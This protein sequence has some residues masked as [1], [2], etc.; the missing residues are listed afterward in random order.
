MFE[1]RR[2]WAFMLAV[3]MTV[4]CFAACDSGSKDTDTQ[5]PSVTEAPTEA[6]TEVETETE[7][8]PLL[9]SSKGLA[10]ELNS[11]GKGYTCTGMGTCTDTDIV[12]GSYNG[13][14]VIG[15]GAYAFYSCDNLTD[16]YFTGTEEEWA[17]IT[18]GDYNT[19][20][21]NATIHYNYVPE[22]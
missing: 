2:F 19:P 10:F 16:V 11:D 20:L 12:I 15:I 22:T 9:P 4:S 7:T 3:A 18:I 14:P 1:R 8:E 5:A 21:Q 17:A 13:L 6:A